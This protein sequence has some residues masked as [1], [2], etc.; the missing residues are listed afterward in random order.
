MTKDTVIE[1]IIGLLSHT[2]YQV[3]SKGEGKQ[4]MPAVMFKYAQ[5][6][7]TVLGCEQSRKQHHRRLQD[8]DTKKFF[9]QNIFAFDGTQQLP[10]TFQTTA[11][12]VEDNMD[13][14]EIRF[15]LNLTYYQENFMDVD[16]KIGVRKA[17]AKA[18][19]VTEMRVQQ[20]DVSIGR[21]ESCKH[22]T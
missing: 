16:V 7:S 5:E 17:I 20:I 11:C 21:L 3:N 1:E 19:N 18:A 4:S 15:P 10:S 12:F 2:D 8:Y 22:Y 6:V 14:K 9:R 13:D